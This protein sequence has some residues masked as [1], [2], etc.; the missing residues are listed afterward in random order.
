MRGQ[1]VA[2]VE[3]SDYEDERKRLVLGRH[4]VASDEYYEWYA[5]DRLISE[6]SVYHLCDC[7]GRRC[8]TKLTSRD[9]RELVHIPRWRIVNTG[10]MLNEGYSREAGLSRLRE[11][12][13]R[14][15]PH[16]V[17]P[18][19]PPVRDERGTGI[20]GVVEGLGTIDAEAGPKRGRSEERRKEKERKSPR[21]SP[22][23]SVGKLL[24]DKAKTYEENHPERKKK[25]RKRKKDGGGDRVDK[26]KVSRGG[27]GVSTDSS[28]EGSDDS[29]DSLFHLPP[30]RGGA[31]LWRSTRVAC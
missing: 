30:S 15:V 28:G 16:P 25:K 21:R 9:R 13:R 22:R 31:E 29:S 12:V 19:V 1:G 24:R 10:M 3:I 27:D 8:T 14:F 26:K 2:L 17:L 20:D 5:R 11:G 7:P 6:K 23:G 4:V 18:P